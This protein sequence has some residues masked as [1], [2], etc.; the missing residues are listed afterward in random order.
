MSEDA[1]NVAGPCGARGALSVFL[2][3]T[4]TENKNVAVILATNVPS[5]L[6]R[7]VLDRIDESFEFPRRPLFNTPAKEQRLQMLKLFMERYLYGKILGCAWRC[8]VAT[9][10]QASGWR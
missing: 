6:D 9:I 3:H 4:G 2:H 7:A 1:R 5:V 8:E 10:V